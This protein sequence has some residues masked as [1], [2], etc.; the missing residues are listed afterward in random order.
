MELDSQFRNK[1]CD[2]RVVRSGYSQPACAQC[3]TAG[4]CVISGGADTG[5]RKSWEGR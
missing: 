1:A 5:I 2:Y 4:L 3:N